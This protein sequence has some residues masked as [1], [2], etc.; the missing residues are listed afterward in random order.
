MQR[1]FCTWG[2]RLLT[3]KTI[4]ASDNHT[5]QPHGCMIFWKQQME[6]FCGEKIG[7]N[8][9][10]KEEEKEEGKVKPWQLVS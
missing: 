5:G 1:D 6:L 3:W 10:R 9:Q 4:L 8:D 7:G 2:S